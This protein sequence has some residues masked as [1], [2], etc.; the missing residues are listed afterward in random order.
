M[1]RKRITAKKLKIGIAA[2]FMIFSFSSVSAQQQVSL[3][4]AIKQALQNKAEAKKAALQVKKAE[5]KIDEARAGALPQI[6]ATIS[7]TYNPILQK[8]VLPGEIIG[9]PGELIPVAFGTKWQSVNVVTLNQNIFDQRVF[10]GLKAAKSTREFYLLNSEL[11][12]EQIIENVATAYYQVFVQEENLKTVEESYANTERVRNVIK[13]LVDNGLAKPIDLDRTNVQLTNI[14]SNKQQL[15]NAVEVSKNSLKFYMG[16][17]IENSIELEEKEIVPNPELLGTNVNLET[18]SELKVLNK[19]RELLEYN[20]KATVANLYPTVGLS[21]NYGWQGL[22]NKFPYATGSSQG[23]N[24]GDYASIGVAIKIPIFMG[25]ATK[26]QIQQAEI[27]I[28]DLDQD[29]Q[30]KKLNLSLDYKNAITNMENA[31]INIQSMKDNVDLAEKVQK[32]TQSNYQY[33]L[34]TLTEVLDTENALTQAKQNY[35]NALLDYK[36]AEIKVIKAKGELNT[37]QNL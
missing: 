23:T 10:I 19:Q 32:N 24:W 31:I 29:I 14:K 12:N 11:T 7:N 6:S 15:I 27:D 9:K 35:A 25:G 36:Q 20:K 16:V 13:S 3:Q 2:A 18:R 37:L 34:A 17:P 4:E 30:N 1:K 26:A 28:Q 21:A 5:Y 8:S 33:G 22:G